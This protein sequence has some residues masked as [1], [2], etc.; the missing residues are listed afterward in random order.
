M[1]VLLPVTAM[2]VMSLTLHV[3]A[4]VTKFHRVLV[5]EFRHGLTVQLGLTS[6]KK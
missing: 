6:K 3:I 1:I 4:K 2:L 5:I